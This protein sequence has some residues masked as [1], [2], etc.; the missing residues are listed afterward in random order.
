MKAFCE[1]EYD[2]I[3]KFS[4]FKCSLASLIIKIRD[5]ATGA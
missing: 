4:N 3:N 2:K 5:T 1:D